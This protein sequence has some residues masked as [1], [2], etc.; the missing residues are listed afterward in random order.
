MLV[1]WCLPC[2]GVLTARSLTCS[3]SSPWPWAMLTIIFRHISITIL[4]ISEC[5]YE[6]AAEI[7]DI[8]PTRSASR[9]IHAARYSLYSASAIQRNPSLIPSIK[10]D[11]TETDYSH[12]V[13]GNGQYKMRQES[14]DRL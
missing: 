14:Q 1:N 6:T 5:F 10:F 2:G 9:L 11:G 4:G 12:V 13:E 7:S 8:I 3:N